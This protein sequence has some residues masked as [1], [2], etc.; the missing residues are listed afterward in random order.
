M[1][2]LIIFQPVFLFA[3]DN[4]IIQLQNDV[5]APLSTAQNLFSNSNQ[6]PYTEDV[7]EEL[8]SGNEV[9]LPSHDRPNSTPV[10][11]A[12]LSKVTMGLLTAARKSLKN[13]DYEVAEEAYKQSLQ[14]DDISSNASRVKKV[15]LQLARLLK[16]IKKNEEAIK[17]YE[18]IAPDHP[19]PE[20]KLEYIR[21]LHSVDRN[22]EALDLCE[23]LLKKFPGF[24]KAELIAGMITKS[25]GDYMRSLLHFDKYLSVRPEDPL[26][27]LETGNLLEKMQKWKQAKALYDR[28]IKLEPDNSQALRNRGNSLVHLGEYKL[29]VED[30]NA[31]GMQDIPWV[32]RLIR[33]AKSQIDIAVAKAESKRRLESEQETLSE[34]NSSKGRAKPNTAN[35]QI[36]NKEPQPELSDRELVV[37]SSSDQVV[38]N[39]VPV[40]EPIANL[41]TKASMLAKLD[42]INFIEFTPQ[43]ISDNQ[44]EESDL[45]LIDETNDQS[46]YSETVTAPTIHLDSKEKAIDKDPQNLAETSSKVIIS[47]SEL[48]STNAN[49]ARNNYVTLPTKGMELIQARSFQKALPIL[50]LEVKRFPLS[51]EISQALRVALQ[52]MSLFDEILQELDRIIALYP[53]NYDLQLNRSY[54][55][56]ESGNVGASLKK[57]SINENDPYGLYL[58]AMAM[59]KVGRVKDA[60]IIQERLKT[61]DSRFSDQQT[62]KFLWLVR[63][64]DYLFAYPLGKKLIKANRPWLCYPMA[65]VARALDYPVEAV[66]Y[67][68]QSV[69]DNPQNSKAYFELSQIMDQLGRSEDRDVFLQKALSIEPSNTEYKT[70]HQQVALKAP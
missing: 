22:S 43:G 64:K 67:L 6:N 21:L 70:Y 2:A 30:L 44:S 36:V 8:F 29:A 20:V 62:G 14:Q 52:S 10:V 13:G 7:K 15:Q 17:I 18:A 48:D 55:L 31:S 3:Q 60:T 65:V 19:K 42:S 57:V 50:R 24:F 32:E 38:Q 33:Y 49:Q 46:S 58:K 23:S 59:R 12:E 61:I 39:S 37:S 45:I 56:L 27:L 26:A 66:L 53:E 54:Y 28:L 4:Q 63:L 35:I 16:K 41:D 5:Q 40:E 25:E 34:E 51:L 68:T 9:E 69:Q 47:D 11:T 1:L